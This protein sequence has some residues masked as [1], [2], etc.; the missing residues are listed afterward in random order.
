MVYL[1]KSWVFASCIAVLGCTNNSISE[2]QFESINTQFSNNIQQTIASNKPIKYQ[3]VSQTQANLKQ[4]SD[5]KNAASNAVSYNSPPLNSGNYMTLIKTGQTNRFGNPLYKL[6]LFV[7]GHLTYSHNTVSGRYNTQNRD[8]HT[9]GTE[10]PLPNGRYSIA[11]HYVAGTHPE[12]GERFL[13]IL[14]QFSTGRSALGIHYDPSFE[15]S[16]KDDGTAG[17]IAL[18]NRSE[19]DKVLNYIQTYQP[20]FLEVQI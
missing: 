11:K 20:Q 10:A 9:A 3:N 8:R 7:N 18:T 14:P 6:E 15:K 13:S 1:R 4:I 12:V 5:R 17:C 2:S 19:L 16:I